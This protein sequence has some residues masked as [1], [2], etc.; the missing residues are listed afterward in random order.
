MTDTQQQPGIRTRIWLAD[1]FLGRDPVPLEIRPKRFD[2]K[3]L[4]SNLS[5]RIDRPY[6]GEGLPNLRN[7]HEFRLPWKTVMEAEQ[8]EHLD[9][10][11]S[12]GQPFD[13]GLWKHVYDFFDG[14][15]TTTT[16]YLQRRQLL[17]NVTPLTEYPSYPTT[18]TFY[19]APYGTVGATATS[20]TVVQKTTA[21][22][23]GGSPSSGEVWVEDTGHKI[24]GFWLSTVE[25]AEAPADVHDAL[26]IAYMPLYAVV[27]DEEGPRSY[28]EGMVEPRDYRLVE[29][30]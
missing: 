11:S 5:L 23:A 1:R 16:F 28:S 9:M 29:S 4:T 30:S 3:T 19:D 12:V 15:G 13:L 20:K 17:P 6:L 25:C 7:R 24:G 8:I 22:I 10:L 14:D 21:D 18:A 27:I 26:V 2:A